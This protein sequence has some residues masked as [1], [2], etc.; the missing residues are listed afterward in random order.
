MFSAKW[1]VLS[2][3]LTPTIGEMPLGVG[4]LSFYLPEEFSH[5][6]LV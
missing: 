1:C 6:R 2:V 3:L 4:G 5:R